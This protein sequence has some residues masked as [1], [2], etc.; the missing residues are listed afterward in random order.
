MVPIIK[1]EIFTKTTIETKCPNGNNCAISSIHTER[2][3]DWPIPRVFMMNISWF[4]NTKLSYV[5]TLTFALSITQQFYLKDLYSGSSSRKDEFNL[6]KYH[7]KS[8]VC[9]L[10]AHYF[11][12]VKHIVE[13][14][15]GRI[16]VVWKHYDDDK[17]IMECD[18]WSDMIYKILQYKI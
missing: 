13:E 2:Y 12:F 18:D 9:F 6:I 10:D 14:D 1:R 3:I 8:I 16:H 11:T 5:D 7:L 17:E 15:D 4:L